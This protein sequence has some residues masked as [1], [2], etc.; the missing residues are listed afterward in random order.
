MACDR[1]IE[2][3][4]CQTTY[5]GIRKHRPVPPLRSARRIFL[6]VIVKSLI[7]STNR[8]NIVRIVRST[9]VTSDT[10]SYIVGLF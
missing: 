8:Q 10:D 1:Q 9:L 4:Q 5:V 3:P 2:D 7:S 6:V